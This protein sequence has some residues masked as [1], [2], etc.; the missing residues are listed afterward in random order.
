MIL[1]VHA[2]FQELL[3][4][5]TNKMVLHN[6][7]WKYKAKKA[8]ERKHAKQLK[9]G[10]EK[11]SGN[12]NAPHVESDNENVSESGSRSDDGHSDSD[13]GDEDENGYN[14]FARAKKSSN[15]W[16]FA[17]PIVDE[18]ILKDPE[19]ISQLN[20]IKQE[21]EDR[22]QYMRTKVSDKLKSGDIKLNNNMFEGS[23]EIK[24][25]RKLK[26][27][28]LLN[29]KLNEDESDDGESGVNNKGEIRE[30]T[31]E[32]KNSF[33]KL[34]QKINHKKELEQLKS[35]MDRINNKGGHTKILELHSKSGKDN[36]K[37][38]VNDRLNKVSLTKSS[39][40]LDDLVEEVLGVNL[41]DRVEKPKPTQS[42]DLDSL[43]N[44]SIPNTKIEPTSTVNKPRS[45][46]VLDQEDDEFLD[47]LL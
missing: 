4:A 11:S 10:T 19:Y 23:Q 16:R 36:Y 3:I 46:I 37:H 39:D 43:I 25:L 26:A 45:K 17:D 32:E 33:L 24:G 13:D 47:S 40:N 42:F 22:S 34:Q 9:N 2:S 8:V 38:L 20:A 21:E 1:P 12:Q 5:C 30:F 15:A 28:D 29:W 6:D 7:K 18:S 41:K 14:K 35:R 27:G 31:E 44:T